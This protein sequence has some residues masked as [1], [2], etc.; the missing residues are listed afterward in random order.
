MPFQSQ[1][2]G[3]R[4]KKRH[5]VKTPVSIGARGKNSYRASKKLEVGDSLLNHM[6][7]GKRTISGVRTLLS[8]CEK[9][10]RILKEGG[11]VKR[12]G[13]KGLP[14]MRSASPAQ[15]KSQGKVFRPGENN[16][17]V[18]IKESQQRE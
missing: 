5:G 10:S 4:D 14:R 11:E 8:A 15:A 16:K 18:V 1:L 12:R 13:N 3:V 7:S 17:K 9:K 6:P 2:K